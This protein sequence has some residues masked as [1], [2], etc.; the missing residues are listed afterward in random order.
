VE[1]GR[2]EGSEVGATR[3]RSER[4]PKTNKKAQADVGGE[5][6]HQDSAGG[7]QCRR[8]AS[9]RAPRKG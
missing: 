3:V 4:E 7:E 2:K 8:S 6:Q 5:Q 1:G 9:F